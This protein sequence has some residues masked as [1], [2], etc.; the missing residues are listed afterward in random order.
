MVVVFDCALPFEGIYLQ[1]C[2]VAAVET[3]SLEPDQ[4][5]LVDMKENS[6]PTSILLL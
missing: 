2:L 4:S 3:L 5:S 6:L 1:H